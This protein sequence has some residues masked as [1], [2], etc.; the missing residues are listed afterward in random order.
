MSKEN[1]DDA[2]E[3]IVGAVHPKVSER[4]FE[5]RTILI[6][7]EISSRVAREVTAQLLALAAASDDDITVFVHSEGGHVEAG[8]SIHDMMNFVKP[9]VKMVG[10][11]WVASAG[12]HIYLAVP[13][14]DRYCL[15]NTRFL[16][17]QPMGGAS[18]QAVD[19]DIQATEILK[20]R[21]QMNQILADH[22][23]R[24]VEQI[25]KDTERDYY[26]SATEAKEYGIVDEVASRRTSSESRKPSGNEIGRSKT[27]KPR[28][29]AKAGRDAKE[30]SGRDAAAS[31]LSIGS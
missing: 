12:V 17:H 23:G 10:T 19:I 2:A 5:S 14:K 4:L 22:T 20:M 1:E 18:G 16:I 29:P 31:G 7:G 6:H 3:A 8:D 11:G 24:D 30:G 9:R 25:A 15:P 26:L 27:R 28:D 21:E 13:K